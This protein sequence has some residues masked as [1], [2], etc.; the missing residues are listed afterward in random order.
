MSGVIAAGVVAV[1]MGT[2]KAVDGANQKAK[3]ER[4]AKSNIFSPEEMPY[5][6]GLSTDLAARNYTNGMPGEAQARNDINRN[7]ASQFYR[8]QQGATS[9]AD[10]QDLATRIGM[11]TNTATNQLAQQGAQYKANALGEYQGA[12][13]NQAQWQKQLYNNNTLQP[14]LRTANLASSMYG[15]GQQNLYSGLDDIGSS[16]I[17]AAT[18]FGGGNTAA[19]PTGQPIYNSPYATPVTANQ[20]PYTPYKMPDYTG[21]QQF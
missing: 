8:G 16:A 13:G 6:V 2:Y 7:S 15:A 9:G 11:G 20:T 5:E 18:A 12:L 10:I 21:W 3:A 4:L 14:Y 19:Q 17:G 1:G